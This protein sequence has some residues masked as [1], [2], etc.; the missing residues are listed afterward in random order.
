M[1]LNSVRGQNLTGFLTWAGRIVL[2]ALVLAGVMAQGAE[3]RTA[4]DTFADLV[5]RLGPTVVNVSTTQKLAAARPGPPEGFP[6][7]PPGSPFEDFF[8][9]FFERQQRQN[10]QPRSIMSLG[11]GFIIDAKGYIV[12]NNHVIADA[13]EVKV[14]LH[15][16]TEL[17]AKVIGR[18]SKTDIAVLKVETKRPLPTAVWGNSDQLR[19]GDWVLAIGNPFGLGG[20]VTAGIVSARGRNIRAGPYDDF[21]QTDASINKGNSGGPLFDAEGGVVGVATAIFSQTGGSIGI[22]FAV[23]AAVA[24]PVVDQLIQFGRTRRGWLGVKIQTVTDEIAESLGLDN[25]RGALVAGV[26]EGGPA[27]KGGIDPG[28]V[29]TSFDNKPVQNMN[30]LPRLVADTPIGRDVTVELWR[31]GKKITTKVAI[32]ELQEAEE[33]AAVTPEKKPGGDRLASEKAVDL[34]GMKVAQ[35]NDE[36]RNR[37]ELEPDVAGVVITDVTADGPAAGKDIQ[38][39]DVIVEVAQNPVKTADDLIARIKEARDGKRRSVLLLIMRGGDRR[40][41]AVPFKS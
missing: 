20:S 8:K 37:F 30:A 28:D 18:D 6:Q 11:S 15:D 10:G 38:P 36:V 35:I 22:G 1:I 3:A 31:K 24:K 33:T 14:I 23:P 5:D 32:G 9:D 13:D 16:D 17:L 34:L 25:S 29:I 21:I 40:F 26:N 39:G 7:L 12:T 4:P 27:A 2:L 41:I 19:V